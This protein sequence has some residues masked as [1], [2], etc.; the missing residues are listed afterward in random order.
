MNR[1]QSERGREKERKKGGE[2]KAR[3][4]GHEE[5]KQLP[6][7]SDIAKIIRE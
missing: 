1:D 5:R 7:E 4:S 3:K 6:S 2:R